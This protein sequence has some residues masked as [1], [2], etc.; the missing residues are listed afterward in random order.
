MQ[1]EN[2]LSRLG[3]AAAGHLAQSHGLFIDGRAVA[4]AASY[5]LIDPSSGQE[6]ARAAQAGMADVDAAVAAARA[7]LGGPWAR[8]RPHQREECM[9][10]LAALM[11]ANGRELSEIE[12]LC[13]GRLLANTLGVD[14]QYSAHV[15]RYMAGWATKISGETKRVSAPY[16]PDGELSGFTF[17]EP[18]GV[19]G[20]IVPWNVA[21]G[22]AIWK[23]APALAAGATVVLKPAPTTPLSALR[24]ADLALEAG[25]PAGVLNIVTGSGPEVGQAL[26]RHPD[27][28]LVTFTRS[29]GVGRQIA[30]EAAGALK[31]HS[32]ELGA[33]PR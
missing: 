22:I 12:T 25:I 1:L 9:L 23:I 17:R 13:S 31:R 33:S 3:A 15:L 6:F 2:D 20:A 29:T 11:E 16:V 28:A 18:V 21:L 10:R 24:L 19:V 5:P 8:M 14:V 27:V 4:T 32:L 30:V 26:I 7:A